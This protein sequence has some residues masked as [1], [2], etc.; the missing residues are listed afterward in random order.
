MKCAQETHPPCV[1]VTATMGLVGVDTC[2]G[3]YTHVG[4]SNNN[5]NG[6]GGADGGGSCCLGLRVEGLGIEDPSFY[7]IM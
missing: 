6:P 5:N 7:F 2:C 4:P 1:K 3:E